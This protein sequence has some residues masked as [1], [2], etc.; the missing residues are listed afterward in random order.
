M[1][2]ISV[3]L[4]RHRTLPDELPAPFRALDW[5]RVQF[6]LALIINGQDEGWI[7][8][9][10]LPPLQDALSRELRLLMQIWVTPN[11]IVVLNAEKAQ[12]YGL[13]QTGANVNSDAQKDL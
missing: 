4:K 6:K 8:G 5:D 13:F 9:D 12:S 1:L 7:T 3:Y 10:Y 11:S 2:L